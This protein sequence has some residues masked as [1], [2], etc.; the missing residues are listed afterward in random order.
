MISTSVISGVL[1]LFGSQTT[2][3]WQDVGSSPLPYSRINGAT[4]DWGIAATASVAPSPDSRFL[5]GQNKEGGLRVLRLVGNSATVVSNSDIESILSGMSKVS[6]AVGLTY[7]SYG[8]QFYQ[9]TFPTEN[10]TLL[11]DVNSN[12]WSE[13]QTGL[14]LVG[15]HQGELGVAAYGYNLISDS[16]TGNIYRMDPDNHT[17]NGEYI[18]R[19][20]VSRHVHFDQNESSISSICLDMET[21]VGGLVGLGI[22][23]QIVMQ[24][25]KDGGKTF[26]VEKPVSLGELGHYRKT[27]A[28]W[29][30]LGRSND[31]VFKFTVTDPVKFVVI[32][33][34]ADIASGNQVVKGG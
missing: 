7:Y 3:F 18:K 8:H 12:F 20:L 29:R 2:E 4:Q 23:P 10:R 26:G 31:F 24:V 11:L 25:S 21:G 1:L 14:D 32:S 13:S 5:L 22:D 16:T 27:R 34:T 15:R 17:D 9:I 28:I 19:Q 30:R 6:D 33:A